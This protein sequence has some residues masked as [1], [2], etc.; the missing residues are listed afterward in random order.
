MNRTRVMMFVRV[1]GLIAF[2]SSALILQRELGLGGIVWGFV[3][4]S[5]VTAIVSGQEVL[6]ATR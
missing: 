5:V 1:A 2:L 6:R 4:A 3:V